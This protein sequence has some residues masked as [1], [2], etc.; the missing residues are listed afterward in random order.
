MDLF[1]V[2]HHQSGSETRGFSD[3]PRQRDLLG[4]QPRVIHEITLLV[5]QEHFAADMPQTELS[6]VNEKEEII[7]PGNSWR[8][9][10][11]WRNEAAGYVVLAL[12]A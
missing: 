5:P 6:V 8:V 9:T 1:F 2:R 12:Q 3:G 10:S 11:H 4:L 7:G